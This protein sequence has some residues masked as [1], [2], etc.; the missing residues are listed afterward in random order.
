[1]NNVLFSYMDMTIHKGRRWATSD[2]YLRPVLKRRNLHTTIKT[3]VEKVVL[4]G[5]KAVG[6][7]YRAAGQVHKVIGTDLVLLL[8]PSVWIEDQ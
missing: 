3:L 5:N 4:D 1:M 2:G 7:K 8:H 6:V